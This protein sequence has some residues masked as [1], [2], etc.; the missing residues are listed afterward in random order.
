MNIVTAKVGDTITLPGSATLSGIFSP[1]FYGTN[2]KYI[3]VLIPPGH[4]LY[5]QSKSIKGWQF[6]GAKIQI[7]S[8]SGDT[9]IHRINILDENEVGTTSNPTWLNHEISWDAN[10]YLYLIAYY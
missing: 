8:G 2:L 6:N 5:F 3:D 1:D 7:V 9:H 10:Q 4:T